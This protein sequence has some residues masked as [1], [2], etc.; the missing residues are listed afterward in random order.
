MKPEAPSDVPPSTKPETNKSEQQPTLNEKTKQEILRI[1]T[2]INDSKDLVRKQNMCSMYLCDISY[3]LRENK[4]LE[5][6]RKSVEASVSASLQGLEKAEDFRTVATIIGHNLVKTVMVYLLSDDELKQK[7]YT[8]RLAKMVASYYYEFDGDFNGNARNIY[9][10]LSGLYP[11]K[12]QEK[13]Q[14]LEANRNKKIHSEMTPEK[15]MAE[16]KAVI[17][18]LSGDPIMSMDPESVFQ[19]LVIEAS[20]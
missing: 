1:S 8:E 20:K 17:Q 9:L 13:Y 4:N 3:Y 12:Y 16:V 10:R 18:S 11:E 6:L 14:S 19:E 2:V 7:P 5:L 15:F